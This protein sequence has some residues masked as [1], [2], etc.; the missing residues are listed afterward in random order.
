MKLAVISDIHSNL[1]A[2]E[3]T[4]DFLQQSKIDRVV[5]LGDI[6]GYGAQ[7]N[8]CIELVQQSCSHVVLGNHDAVATGFLP[9]R[10][11]NAPGQTAMRWT[12]DILSKA[13]LQYL[14]TLPL[15]LQLDEITLVHS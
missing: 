13:N 11:L 2:L 5:C 3:R 4:L 14:S 8:E 7:P 6:V 10:H 1:P 9:L 15:I 12:V